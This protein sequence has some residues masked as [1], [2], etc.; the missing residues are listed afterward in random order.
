MDV[1]ELD[2]GRRFGLAIYPFH[3]FSELV[4]E[5]DR[6]TTLDRIRDHLVEGGR[7]VLTLHNPA[8]RATPVDGR[9]RREMDLPRRDTPGRLELWVVEEWEAEGRI[10]KGT[11]HFEAHDAEGGLDWRFSHEFRYVLLGREEVEAMAAEEGF[12][13]ATLYGD[14]ERSEFREDESPEMI[15]VLER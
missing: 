4:A 3:A 10:V 7:L 12:R 6:R 8:V 9:L 5:E 11:E 15:W 2:L 1:R 13:V 14:Y